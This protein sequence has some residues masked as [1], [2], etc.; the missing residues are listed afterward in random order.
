MNIM[1]ICVAAMSK[2][3]TLENIVSSAVQW[4]YIPDRCSDDCKDFIRYSLEQIPERRLGFKSSDLVMNHSFFSDVDINNIY[5]G[6]GPFYPK[7]GNDA[8]YADDDETSTQ[9]CFN[10]IPEKEATD[11]PNFIDENGSESD[12]WETDDFAG[13]TYYN[14]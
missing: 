8:K 11:I 2:E 3:E 13:Y 9:F 14:I 7:S 1:L 5:K 10:Q 4:Q 12:D 6:Y